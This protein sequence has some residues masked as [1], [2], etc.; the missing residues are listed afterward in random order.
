MQQRKNNLSQGRRG[1]V[2]FRNADPIVFTE[3]G[4]EFY[5]FVDGQFDFNA[6]LLAVI[7]LLDI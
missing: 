7:N 6:A 1:A 5:V 4:I 3:S 2:D